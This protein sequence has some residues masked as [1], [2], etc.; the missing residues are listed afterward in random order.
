MTE[1]KVASA[2]TVDDEFAPLEFVVS[3]EWNQQY[4][5]AEE[6]FHPRYWSETDAGPPI[7][8][9]GL[10]LYM[11]NNARSPSYFLIPGGGALHTAEQTFFLNPGRVGKRFRV[12]WKV[13]KTYEKR[14][15]SYQEIETC[16]VDE[17]GTPVMRRISEE[18]YS[19]PAVMK[20]EK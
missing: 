1:R 12:T 6:D 14:G 8:H 13:V 15:K 9:P 17:D 18:A 16:I 20:H 11:S 4:L 7:V 10:L 2:L 3:P 5:Y 19:L